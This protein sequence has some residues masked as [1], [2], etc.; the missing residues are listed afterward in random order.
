MNRGSL[1]NY[2][3]LAAIAGAFFLAFLMLK[4]FLG[5]LCL[6]AIFAVTLQPM[7]QRMLRY[8]RGRESLSALA[9]VLVSIIIVL[10]PMMV[11]GFQIL[12]EAQQL[13]GVV[14]SGQSA[15]AFD[16]W[17]AGVGPSLDR[18]FPG[19]EERIAE[20]AASMDTYLRTA[21]TWL[22]QNLGVAFSGV[23]SFLLS[24][25]IFF[26]TLYYLL[27]D[28]ARLT[29]AL[30]E[31]SPLS[32]TE[33]QEVLRRLEL[34]VNSVV[35]GKLFIALMQ[36]ALTGI[37]FFLFGIPNPVL[38][39]LIAAVA[40]LIPPMG[41]ALILIPGIAYLFLTGAT[42]PA[43]GLSIWGGV[44]VGLVDNLLGPKLM[45]SGMQLHPL[46]VVLSVLGGIPIFGPIGVFLGPL[47]ISL[48]IALLSLYSQP[49]NEMQ[50]SNVQ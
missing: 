17:L 25:F 32:D 31:L 28:G 4:P 36:G 44:A 35:K 22:I 9:T 14:A 10:I 29:R 15:A 40:S 3:L 30:V 16:A 46:L 2:F 27:R 20:F 18:Y 38:W 26:V 39:G 45:S 43:I 21:L 24:L 7:Y 47:V 23:A 41:T 34:A 11:I 6:G 12:K 37:G 42:I 49:R 8:T 50:S 1:Q 13:Y 5:P 19:A 33:D 48:L